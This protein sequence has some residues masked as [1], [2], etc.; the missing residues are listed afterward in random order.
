MTTFILL[1]DRNLVNLAKIGTFP[2]SSDIKVFVLHLYTNDVPPCD[3]TRVRIDCGG[4]DIDNILFL[5]EADL[6]FVIKCKRYEGIKTILHTVNSREHLYPWTP[7]DDM[8][9]SVFC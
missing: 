9:R 4:F 6:E 5:E 8:F 2:L 7:V 1:F 3:L